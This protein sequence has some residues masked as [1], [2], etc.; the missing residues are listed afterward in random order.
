MRDRGLQWRVGRPR[1]RRGS[2][3]RLGGQDGVAVAAMTKNSNRGDSDTSR[4][5]FRAPWHAYDLSDR[6]KRSL[7]IFLRRGSTGAGHACHAHRGGHRH[8]ARVGIRGRQRAADRRQGRVQ[9]GADLLPLRLG[10]RPSDGRAR[11]RQ[12]AADGRLPRAARPHRHAGRTHRRRPG[13]V[14]G[15]SR[16]RPCHRAGRDDQRSAVHAGAGRAGQRV[17]RAVAF[18]RGDGGARCAGLVAVRVAGAAG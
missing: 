13:G 9:P 15:G 6:L 14:R 11:G 4:R 3:R 18:V 10:S 7:K 12:R 17:P 5:A 1:M 8:A 16:R 2:A